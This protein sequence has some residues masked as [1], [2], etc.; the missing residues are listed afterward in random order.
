[1]PGPPVSEHLSAPPA[2]GEEPVAAPPPTASARRPMTA[3]RPRPAPAAPPAQPVGD[4]SRSGQVDEPKRPNPLQSSLRRRPLA[5]ALQFDTPTDAQSN[6]GPPKGARPSDD[7]PSLPNLQGAPAAGVA[8]N[9]ESVR[10]PAVAPRT[11]AFEQP[12]PPPPPAPMSR[13]YRGPNPESNGSHLPGG[14]VGPP[15]APAHGVDPQFRPPRVTAQGG[16]VRPG[17]GTG[18][19]PS[20]EAPFPP[21]PSLPEALKAF[22]PGA[23]NR[24]LDVAMNSGPQWKPGDDDVMPADGRRARRPRLW[25]R[26]PW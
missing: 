22:A 15:A 12:A 21:A 7:R 11:P 9:T 5:S 17:V 10:F 13:P 25:D 18:R 14:S 23:P 20:T 2:P 16:V 26:L 6:G 1:M 4:Q 19:H 24:S 8:W 3:N